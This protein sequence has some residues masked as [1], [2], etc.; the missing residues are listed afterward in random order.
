[1]PGFIA[2]KLCPHLVIVRANFDRYQQV[3]EVVRRVLEQ[4]DPNFSPMGLDESYLDLTDYVSQLLAKEK[5]SS[6]NDSES[7]GAEKGDDEFGEDVF[8]SL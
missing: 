8:V 2:K 5:K 3:S 7:E 4:F 6:R 1:M